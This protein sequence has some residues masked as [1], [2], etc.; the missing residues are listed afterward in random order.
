MAMRWAPRSSTAKV[1]AAVAWTAP[2]KDWEK[3][4]SPAFTTSGCT[5]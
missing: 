4:Y 2:G 5:A 3:T 1:A